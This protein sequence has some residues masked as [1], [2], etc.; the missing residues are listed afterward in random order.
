MSSTSTISFGNP[1]P[2]PEPVKVLIGTNG[3][4]QLQATDGDH[5]LRG[6]LGNDNL[7]GSTGNDVLYGGAGKDILTGGAGRDKFVFDTKPSKAN[8]TGSSISPSKTTRS[9]WTTVT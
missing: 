8:V 3:A 5:V 4:D 7:S 2:K 9:R 6:L 1:V